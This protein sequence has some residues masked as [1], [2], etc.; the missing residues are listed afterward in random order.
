MFYSKKFRLLLKVSD[1]FKH[2]G[3]EVRAFVL[4]VFDLGFESHD[5]QT[6]FICLDINHDFNHVTTSDVTTIFILGYIYRN[7]ELEMHRE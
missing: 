1:S 2:G 5:R 4:K 3:V 6:F 7:F